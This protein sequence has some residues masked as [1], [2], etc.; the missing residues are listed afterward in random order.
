MTYNVPI[1][2]SI[3]GFANANFKNSI[4]NTQVKV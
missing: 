4:C 2:K 1:L 3:L